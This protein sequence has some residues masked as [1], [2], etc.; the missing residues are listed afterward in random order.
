MDNFIKYNPYNTLCA[1]TVHLSPH[2][3]SGKRVEASL[4]GQRCPAALYLLAILQ[5][6]QWGS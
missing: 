3:L 2:V 5:G 1:Q 6:S 4:A